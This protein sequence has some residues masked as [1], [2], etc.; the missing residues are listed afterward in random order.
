ML[1]ESINSPNDLKKLS[2][3]Q[4]NILCTEIRSRIVDVVSKNGGHLASSLGAVEIITAL[5]YCLTMPSEAIVF[6]VGHQAYSHKILTGRNKQFSTVRQFGGLSGFPTHTESDYDPFTAGHSSDAV[7]LALGLSIGGC[8][9]AVAVIGDGSLSGGLC[10]EGLNNAGHLKKDLLVVLNTNE[11]SIAPSVGAVSVYLNKIISQPLYNRFRES[12]E[13]FIRSRLPKGKVILKLADKF[14]KELKGFFVPG[15]LFEELGF[16]YFG[17]L[18]GHNLPLLITTLKNLLTFKG[19]ILLHVVTKKGKGYPPAE[20]EP[21]RFHGAGPFDIATGK[22]SSPSACVT[23][24]DIFSRKMVAVGKENKKV[25]AITAAMP[26]GTGLDKFRDCYPERFFDVGIA[27]AHAICFAA[28][29]AKRGLKPIVAIYSTFLQRSYDQIIESIGVQNAPVVLCLDRAGISGEDGVTHQGN[30]DIVYL[31]SVPG[32]VVMAASS[33]PELE[34]M[35]DFALTMGRPCAIRYPKEKA[36][37][38]RFSILGKSLGM[39]QDLHLGKA[40]VLREGK[41]VAIIALGAMVQNCLEAADILGKEGVDAC[42]IN[43]RF[44]KPLD[45]EWL[46]TLSSRYRYLVTVE[47]GILDGGFGSAVLEVVNRP[48]ARLG[49]PC[50]FIE[51]GKRSQLL[52][53]YAL[54]TKG[55]AKSIKA[56]CEREAL[57]HTPVWGMTGNTTG[58]SL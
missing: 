5:H 27:E 22:P 30:F 3:Q 10:F 2:L 45:K 13:H 31:R 43:A 50:V 21:V 29:L 44:V 25:V 56:Y 46:L 58:G 11:L 7:S 1:L 23:Y 39:R 19:P 35:L 20:N 32:L 41:D 17:P 16:R 4:L 15:M 18:D 42:V 6:D 54:D 37:D 48:I 36:A 33:G 49:L 28:G 57:P 55:I 53:K 24:T 38:A 47:D 12:L 51:H 40:E 14:E 34:A 9:K 8:P 26:E 52:E